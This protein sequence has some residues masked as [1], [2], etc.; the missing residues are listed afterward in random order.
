MNTTKK[1]TTRA[2]AAARRAVKIA[3]ARELAAAS[4][5]RLQI[6][7]DAA[8]AAHAEK[9]LKLGGSMISIPLREEDRAASIVRDM[10]DEALAKRLAT[11][12]QTF[13]AS[14]E[15]DNAAQLASIERERIED[16]LVRAVAVLTLTPATRSFL[17]ANDPQALAQA[18]RALDAARVAKQQRFSRCSICGMEAELHDDAVCK[19]EYE[20]GL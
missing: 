17:E 5:E 12:S 13:A 7:Q 8:E 15:A 11:I 19:K 2:A 3:K 20:G 4:I 6:A 9:R 18:Q 14:V 10:S 16:M 1:S